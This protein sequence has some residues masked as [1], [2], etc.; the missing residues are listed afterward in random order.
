MIVGY[1]NKDEH[2]FCAECWSVEAVA[3]ARPSLVLR[4]E[5]P[6]DPGDN[7]WVVDDCRS[8]GQ[9]VKYKSTMTLN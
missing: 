7:F 3:G 1:T 4:S 5:E 8:C 2:V 9:K 6:D